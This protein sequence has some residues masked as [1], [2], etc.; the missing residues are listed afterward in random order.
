MR[1]CPSC[2][3]PPQR[4]ARLLA[5]DQRRTGTIER[6]RPHFWI[7]HTTSSTARARARHLIRNPYDVVYLLPA[8][9]TGDDAPVAFLCSKDYFP[10]SNRP[11]VK[12]KSE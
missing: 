6:P 11:K 1:F 7:R 2:G 9:R 12:F 8:E 4:V 3:Y 5:L 10:G